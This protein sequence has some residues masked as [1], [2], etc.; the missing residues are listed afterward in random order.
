MEKIGK[1]YDNSKICCIFAANFG[2][3]FVFMKKKGIEKKALSEYFSTLKRLGMLVVGNYSL[4]LQSPGPQENILH[5]GQVFRA[6]EG[7]VLYVVNGSVEMTVN[8]RTVTMHQGDVVVILPDSLAAY[9]KLSPDCMFM[10]LSFGEMPAFEMPHDSFMLT[11]NTKEQARVQAL[12]TLL[13]AYMRTDHPSPRTT[14]LYIDALLSDLSELHHALPSPDA[15]RSQAL[16]DLFVHEL[17]RS[18]NVRHDIP[19]YAAKLSVTPNHLSAI[20]QQH[21]GLTVMQWINRALVLEA[22]VLLRHTDMPVAS[23]AY[24]LGF[25]DATLFARFFRRETGLTARDYRQS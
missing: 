11:L 20:V 17:N 9:D 21:S 14:G 12:F 22:K 18:G 19:Y 24:Q 3:F 6:V 15:S 25:A 8:L 23:I 7:R 5:R 2:K 10:A 4:A 13:D 16:F 1:S